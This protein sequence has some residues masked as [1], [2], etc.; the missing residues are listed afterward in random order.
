MKTFKS[1]WAALAVAACALLASCS[2]P[3]ANGAQNAQTAQSG[4]APTAP[5]AENA[6][7]VYMTAIVDHTALNAVRDGAI[8]ELKARGWE[9][10]K[11][12][13]VKFQ[14]AQ[15]NTSISA[16]IAKQF[17]SEA[18]D[19]MVGIAT[20]SAQSLVAASKTIPIVYA[21]VTDPV[22]AQLVPSWEPS[23]TNV[24]GVSDV[25]PIKTQMD[26]FQNV[27][28]NLKKLGYVYSPGEVNSAVVLESLVK[29]GEARGVEVV[30]APAQRTTDISPAAKS[31]TG[32][33]DAIYTSLDNNVASAY[34]SLYATAKD[35]KLPLFTADVGIVERGAVAAVGISYKE[36]GR[37]TGEV[38][39]RILRGENPGAIPSQVLTEN[40]VYVSPKHA[41]EM[42]I[43]LPQAVLGKAD[44]VDGVPA[45]GESQDGEAGGDE[46]QTGEAAGSESENA[47]QT[48]AKADAA[49]AAAAAEGEDA[50]GSKAAQ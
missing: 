41:R 32:K 24:T 47:D 8:E 5:A 19:V 6:K 35:G 9:E 46:A 18:P 1:A 21:A 13:E 43:E 25:T 14:S 10:G 39:D 12:L 40:S 22:A 45:R 31:L 26:L 28:P 33:V 2:Q 4:A 50:P 16:H 7:K 29:E 44:F 48:S 34:E 3:A 30:A 11:N 23:G 15:G 49:A 36:L 42:G 38:I 37:K 20:P 17:V 27:M